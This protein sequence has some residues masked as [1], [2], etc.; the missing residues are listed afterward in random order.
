MA[1]RKRGGPLR[2]GSQYCQKEKRGKEIGKRKEQRKNI[3]WRTLCSVECCTGEYE[4]HRQLFYLTDMFKASTQ[5]NILLLLCTARQT[6]RLLRENTL[7]LIF[8]QNPDKQPVIKEGQVLK[9]S[10]EA[11]QSD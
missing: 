1:S 5:L 3:Y 8:L 9:S 10:S 6:R 2:F 7:S 11:H 4:V